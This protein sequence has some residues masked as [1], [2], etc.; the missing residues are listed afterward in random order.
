LGILVANSALAGRP[1]L[2]SAGSTDRLP[3]P[4]CQTDEAALHVEL[5]TRRVDNALMTSAGFHSAWISE[6]GATGT[7]GA[8][9][10]LFPWWSFTKTAL[11]IAALRLAEQGRL[12]LDD[13]RPGK[14]FTLRQLL[15]H[16]SGLPDYGRIPAYREAVARRED[17]WD[18][19][20][21]L[22]VADADR[23]LFEPGAGW[24]YS[25]IG[26]LFVGDAIVQGSGLPLA[27]ALRALVLDPIGLMETRLATK[28]ADFRE[29]FWPFLR[30][31][32][33][34]W[35]YHGCLIGPPAEAAQL[36]HALF[37]GALLP[38]GVVASMV[39]RFTPLGDAP[40]GHPG[41]EVGCGMGLMLG[42]MGAAGR[43]FGHAGAGPGCVNVVGHF[44]DL[45]PGITVA[46]F[47]HGEDDGRAQWEAISIALEARK[48]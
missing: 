36:L 21:L 25:N 11:A 33:P 23:L 42:N 47:T 15:T 45:K 22:E 40:P 29:I 19:A 35:A 26:Y 41:T 16:R 48:N 34:R 7:S 20:H 30:G 17:A 46:V 2:I 44:P 39:E 6:D 27:E 4:C 28:R 5:L 3:V 38:P 8:A 14:P 12:Q 9:T 43:A 1:T 10:A 31:Y 24:A 32:D 13:P 18:R 37:E